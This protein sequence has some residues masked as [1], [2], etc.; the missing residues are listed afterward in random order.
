MVVSAEVLSVI[1]GWLS[2]GWLFHTMAGGESSVSDT[3]SAAK[4]RRSVIQLASVI[5]FLL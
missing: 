1:P 4:T 5:T 3:C 2:E